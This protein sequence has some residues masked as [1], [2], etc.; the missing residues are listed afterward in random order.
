MSDFLKLCAG[1]IGLGLL[2]LV[3]LANALGI[4]D[5]SRAVREI[6]EAGVPRWLVERAR[7]LVGAGRLLQL[8]AVPALPLRFLRSDEAWLHA[9]L[10]PASA[11]KGRD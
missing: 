5:Q 2:S 9:G 11:K 10:A 4:V 3:F 6:G 8:T 1:W 7:V